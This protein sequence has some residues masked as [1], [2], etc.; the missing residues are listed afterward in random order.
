MTLKALVIIFKIKKE[1]LVGTISK[2]KSRM[3]ICTTGIFYWLLHY[4]HEIDPVKNVIIL[5]IV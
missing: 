4:T 2:G 5:Y 1:Y 3:K